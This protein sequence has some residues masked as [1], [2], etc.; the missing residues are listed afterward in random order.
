[1][2]RNLPDPQVFVGRALPQLPGYVVHEHLDSGNNGHVFRAHSSATDHALACKIVPPTNLPRTDRDQDLWLQEAKKSNQ[3]RHPSVVHCIDV[4]FWHIPNADGPFVVFLYDYVPGKSLR[5]YMRGLRR[6]KIPVTFIETFLRTMLGLLHELRGRDMEHGDL[7]AGNVIVA[8]PSELDV[9]PQASFRVIDFGVR[10]VTGDARGLGDFLGVAQ[11]LRDLLDGVD[12]PAARPRDKYVYDVLRRDFLARHLIE[13]NPLADQA[14]STPKAM[15]DRLQRIDAEYAEKQASEQRARMLTPF[16][17]PNCEQIGHSHL[18][19][20]SLYSQRFL[21]LREIEARNNLV[22]TGPRGCGKTTVF[23]AL[24]LQHRVLV[25]DDS[26]DDVD[27]I[28]IYYR[29]DDLYFTFPRYVRPERPE[30]IDVPMHF[31]VVTLLAALLD[32]VRDWSLRRFPEEFAK[33]EGNTATRLWGLLD[34]SPP[35]DP[36]AS[37][38][39]ALSNR[40]RR[41]RRRAAHKARVAHDPKQRFGVYFGPEKLLAACECIRAEC[42][43]LRNVPFYFFVDDYSEPKITSD[44]QE[45]LNRLFMHRS[46]DC[47]FKLSTE[48]PVSFSTRDLDGK[49]FVEAREYTLV[50]LGLRYIKD[51]GAGTLLFLEDL[52]ERRF[53]EVEDYPVLNLD[54]LLDPTRG[55]KTQSRARFVPANHPRRISGRRPLRLCAAATFTT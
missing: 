19:L 22:L 6:D 54:D 44:L 51:G 27:Y 38:I 8:D 11:M 29:C 4:N 14:S 33:R 42:G 10:K 40:L 48:S 32:V 52:F 21:G 31:V 35:D 9:E 24:S 15:Y 20:N 1:M 13:T 17:Y 43:H 23:R 28:G 50:N 47:F 25:G 5:K 41:D 36:T 30:A 16:D 7:H 3:L 18:L 37:R 34:W 39:D 55:T 45:N 49:A 46:A 53:R 26:P 12:Y 2:R